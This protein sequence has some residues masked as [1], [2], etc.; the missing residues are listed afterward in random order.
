MT[1]SDSGD[2]WT[3]DPSSVDHLR[4]VEII[5]G[6]GAGGS[7]LPLEYASAGIATTSGNKLHF[8]DA[9][10]SPLNISS[11]RFA[12]VDLVGFS[13]R[14]EFTLASITSPL[15][16]L[17]KLMKHGWNL[18][19]RD[20]EPYLVK[21]DKAIPVAYKRNRLCISGNIRMLEELLD[22]FHLRV[23]RLTNALKHARTI[24]ARLGRDCFAIKTYRPFGVDVT[25]APSSAMLW[26]RTTRV[27]RPGRWKLHE[28]NFFVT[29]NSLGDSLT[30]A[31]PE[32]GGVEEVITIR[33]GVECTPEQDL[34][35]HRTV[36][37]VVPGNKEANGAAEVKVQTIRKQA[38]LLTEQVERALGV[39]DKVIFSA[40]HPLQAWAVVHAIWLHCRFAVSNG[41]AAYESS[42]GKEYHG[43]I[44]LFGETCMGYLR[45]SEKGLASWQRGVWLGKTQSNDAHITSCNGG[46]FITRSVCRIPVPW[47]LT[48]LGNVEIHG[49]ALLLLSARS[50]VG[51]MPARMLPPPPLA[52]AN[53]PATPRA[54]PRDVPAPLAEDD[55]PAC[56]KPRICTI[57]GVEY[58]HEDDRSYTSFTHAEPET[59]R[60][61]ILV[62]QVAAHHVFA[63]EEKSPEKQLILSAI[64]V[65]ECF[66]LLHVDDMLVVTE[67]QYVDEKLIP[68]LTAKHKTS[69]KHRLELL[70]EAEDGGAL[71]CL[72][73]MVYD[74]RVWNP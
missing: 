20:S 72:R 45:P 15:L 34:G 5:L 61:M 42:S 71:H 43:K 52:A 22:A 6:S 48:E 37:L 53:G 3:I 29:D 38:N 46:L 62:C 65:G 68:A 55:E 16:S 8:V 17:G 50:G 63:L 32:P 31:L 67:Q 9:Q 64:E 49:N 23:V 39:T 7:A 14:E 2:V 19:R 60:I 56:K 12:T 28:H 18:E 59:W 25:M 33:H 73:E 35:V 41:E 51:S 70:A 57:A 47:I 30:A 27:K 54:E 10:G 40:L 69:V 4:A 44:C 26:Y 58:E 11:T 24:C 74:Q 36:A 13:L 21:A 1:C 66:I